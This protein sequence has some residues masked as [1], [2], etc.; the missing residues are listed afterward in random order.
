M[1]NLVEQKRLKGEFLSFSFSLRDVFRVDIIRLVTTGAASKKDNSPE[2][3]TDTR[4]VVH[5]EPKLNYKSTRSTEYV[6]VV[7]LKWRYG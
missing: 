5:Q 6:G 7:D 3:M 2:C 4:S 1:R